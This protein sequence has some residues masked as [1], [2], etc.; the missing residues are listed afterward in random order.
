M[1]RSIGASGRA[2]ASEI[3]GWVPP[4]ARLGYAAKGVVYGLVA[5]IAIK[6]GMAS[7]DAGGATEALAS[8][9][10]ENGGRWML[11]AIAIGLLAHVIWRL[12]Q[13][14]MD[15]EHSRTDAKRIAIRLFYALSA[16]IYGSLA[17]TAWDLSQGQGAGSGNGQQIWIGRL[18]EQPFGSWLVMAAGLG[19]IAYGVHQ[20]IKAFRGDVNRRLG[21]GAAV[22][23]RWLTLVGRIGIAARGVVLVPVGWFAFRAGQAYRAEEAA[24]TGEVL[25]MLGGGAM[26]TAVGVGLLAYALHQ[27]AKAAYRRIER[28]D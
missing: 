14:L 12:I 19:V 26:L 3:A 20:L 25:S 22:D 1:N 28:P 17:F 11:A 23:R 24:D 13:A 18:L 9:T 16:V 4:L 8:L 27:V 5:W 21:Y 2:A 7:G 15:P 6:A 10:D